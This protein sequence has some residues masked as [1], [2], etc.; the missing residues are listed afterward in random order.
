M[1][2]Y[3]SSVLWMPQLR[4]AACGDVVYDQV[5]QML[6]DVNRRAKRD[7]WIRAVEKVEAAGL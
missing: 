6:A 7:E 4:L 1:I 2:T 3:D 5:H